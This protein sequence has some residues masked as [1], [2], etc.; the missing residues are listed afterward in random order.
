[1]TFHIWKNK[2]LFLIGYPKVPSYLSYP[3][4]R[5]DIDTLKDF[6]YISK[7]IDNGVN[8]NSSAK[9]I[10]NIAKKIKNER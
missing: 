1:M 9:K 4:L 8:I 3:K 7:L 6:K 10:I 5:F 2:K